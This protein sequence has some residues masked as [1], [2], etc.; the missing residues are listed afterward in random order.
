MVVVVMG[1]KDVERRVGVAGEVEQRPDFVQPNSS[2]AAQIRRNAASQRQATSTAKTG[3]DKLSP[4]AGRIT[5]AIGGAAD[6]PAG[7]GR[8]FFFDEGMA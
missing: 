5:A 3:R 8:D 4:G 6:L 1:A 7:A 2:V